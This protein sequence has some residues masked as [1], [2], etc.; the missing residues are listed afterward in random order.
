LLL[1]RFLPGAQEAALIWR[2]AESGR[3]VIN[4]G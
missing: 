4:V 2:K 3:V 1:P